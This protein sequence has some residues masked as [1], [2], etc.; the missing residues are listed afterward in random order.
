MSSRSLM[1]LFSL[2]LLSCQGAGADA[3]GPDGAGA[4]TVLDAAP[5]A[6]PPVFPEPD[7][8]PR[9]RF[10]VD[11]DDRMYMADAPL[12]GVDHDPEEHPD[13]RTNCLSH[14]GDGFPFCYD[15][16]RGTDFLLR[17]AFERM[18]NGS[19]VVVAAAGGRVLEAVD[20]NYDRC[21]ADLGSVDV[22][23][24]GFPERANFVR[25]GH[26]NGYDSLYYHLKQGSVRVAVGQVVT[27]G[28]A[29]GLVGSS[30]RSATPHLHFQVEDPDDEVFD[31]YAGPASQETSLWVSQRE[32]DG[33]PGGVCDPR[34]QV[35]PE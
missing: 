5:D 21:H 6:P 29:L 10:P 18:D 13:D 9:F 17:G 3:A 4:D 19:A 24:D 28:E 31:P 32:V 20:G 14:R 12:L 16:H 23:C 22:D 8:L 1:Q 2:A 30:G 26:A 27:C 7:A 34:W 11:E 15:G 25:I 35:Y 33:L